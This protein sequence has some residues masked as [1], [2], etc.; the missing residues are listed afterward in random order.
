LVEAFLVGAT[1]VA[2]ASHATCGI[3]TVYKRLRDPA[4]RAKLAEARGLVVQRIADKLSFHALLAIDRLSQLVD[5][6]NPEVAL[7]AVAL[8]L[9]NTARLRE[10][11]QFE[12]RLMALEAAAV[13]PPPTRTKR[14]G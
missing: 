6:S 2:A 10:I 5:D 1:A 3:K 11:E 12:S 8:M 13:P 9:A 4:F 14:A 7:R